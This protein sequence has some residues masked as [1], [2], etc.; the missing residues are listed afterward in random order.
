MNVRV[1]VEKQVEGL[2]AFAPELGMPHAFRESSPSTIIPVDQHIRFVRE[3]LP[4]RPLTMNGCV[5]EADEDS[6]LIY[7]ELR[8][9]DGT[10]A[11]C[12]RT[13]VLHVDTTMRKP[14]PWSS[15]TR[16]AFPQ[17][18]DTAPEESAP[19]SIDMSVAGLAFEDITMDRVK[20]VGAPL[21]GRGAVPRQHLDVHGRMYPY[22]ML[23]RTSDSVPNILYNWRKKVAESAGDL[24]MG[25][26]VL[27]YRLRYHAT[28]VAGDVYE[29]YT[30]FGGAQG[31][32]HNLIHWMMNPA[33]GTPW[34]T[35]QATAITL[36]LDARKAI[37]AP[38]E[39]IRELSEMAAPG[40]EI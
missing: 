8:H 31:K 2:A 25:A 35:M 36:D 40:L 23:G 14:F 7:Q 21:A 24:R 16:A 4:G 39:M 20:A 3:V 13:R 19:R 9:G 12:M 34:A 32:T 1:Y 17:F 28:P 22:W 6:A 37:P 29:L 38:P 11:A 27:E 33:D 18:I 30:S 26:A 5:L 15:R 10:L